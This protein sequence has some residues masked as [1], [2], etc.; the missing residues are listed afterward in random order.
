[1]GKH[2]TVCFSALTN[3]GFGQLCVIEVFVHTAIVTKTLAYSLVTHLTSIKNS[4]VARG[5]GAS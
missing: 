3:N 5:I 4:T 1:M 2:Q